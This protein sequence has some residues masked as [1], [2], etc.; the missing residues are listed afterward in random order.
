[1]E[2]KGKGDERIGRRS[3]RKAWGAVECMRGYRCGVIEM[4]EHAHGQFP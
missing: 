1:M 2:K 4:Q 3:M